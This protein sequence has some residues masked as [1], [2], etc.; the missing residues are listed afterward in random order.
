MGRRQPL[1]KSSATKVSHSPKAVTGNVIVMTTR[2]SSRATKITVTPETAPEVLLIKKFFPGLIQY[3]HSI[4][5]VQVAPV[6]AE[7]VFIVEQASEETTTQNTL[8]DAS[9]HTPYPPVATVNDEEVNAPLVERA[10]L[11]S[12]EVRDNIIYVSLTDTLCLPIQNGDVVALEL[13]PEQIADFDA[14]RAKKKAKLH[15]QKEFQ[16]QRSQVAALIN[17]AESWP[18]P[19]P[20]SEADAIHSATTTSSGLLYSGQVRKIGP[21]A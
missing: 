1:V 18:M 11:P 2:Q 14:E 15:R 21:S 20:M 4:Y 3:I 5:C 19:L 13:S 9:T 17:E 7:A 6:Q 10:A 8:T 16:T 12:S